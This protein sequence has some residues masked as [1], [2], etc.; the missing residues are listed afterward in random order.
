MPKIAAIVIEAGER[1]ELVL[2]L[3]RPLLQ[4]GEVDLLQCILVFRPAEPAADADGLERLQK[5]FDAGDLGQ[6]RTQPLDDLF[7]A[8]L[9]LVPWF[10]ADEQATGIETRAGAAADRR[11]D[12]RDIG[13]FEDDRGRS[14]LEIGHAHER[15]VGRGLREAKDHPGI[16]FRDEPLRDRY[17]QP[18]GQRD[19]RQVDEHRP[20]AKSKHNP[21]Q[22]LVTAIPLLK[23]LTA[24]EKAWLHSK[25]STGTN[26][27]RVAVVLLCSFR[28]LNGLHFYQFKFS[29]AAN[30]I[31]YRAA[32]AR[33]SLRRQATAPAERLPRRGRGPWRR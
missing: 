27:A 33:P 14:L 30:S 4:L 11:A 2:D 32:V 8:R 25:Q 7:F 9:A 10:E 23:S 3:R 29:R 17:D 21:Q 6:L 22:A 5:R 16:F 1:L 19:Q 26:R 20:Q 12:R 18:S 24:T 13:I 15:N 31:D 28:L